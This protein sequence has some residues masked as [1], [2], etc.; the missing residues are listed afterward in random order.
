MTH[1]ASKSRTTTKKVQKEL[2]PLITPGEF[3]LEE[4]LEPLG[5]S[6]N[7]L[8]LALRVPSNRILGIVKG[9]RAISADTAL[10]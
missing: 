5:L 1:W 6:M 4:F 2:L 10:R 7:A 3:L 9:N 8:S